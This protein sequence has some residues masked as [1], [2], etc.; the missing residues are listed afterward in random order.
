MST[1]DI[2][3]LAALHRAIA[4]RDQIIRDLLEAL[5]IVHY[6]Y[7]NV[8]MC[9]ACN[10]STYIEIYEGAYYEYYA[11]EPEHIKLLTHESDCPYQRAV[12]LSQSDSAHDI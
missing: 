10:H 1:S 8:V 2:A 3:E 11:L 6:S 12:T 4:E 7:P 9:D 5:P